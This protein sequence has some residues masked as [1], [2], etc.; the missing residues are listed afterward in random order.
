MQAMLYTYQLLETELLRK[1]TIF[2]G[3]CAKIFISS[4]SESILCDKTTNV[5]FHELLTDS[6]SVVSDMIFHRII[7]E[8]YQNYSLNFASDYI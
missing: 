2:G 6:D 3:G 8:N 5:K 1:F 7:T 4:V